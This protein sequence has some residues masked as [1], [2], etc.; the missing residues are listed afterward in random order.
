[1]PKSNNIRI[2]PCSCAH[3]RVWLYI[4]NRSAYLL[5]RKHNT[6]P[7]PPLFPVGTPH[8]PSTDVTNTP[9]PAPP[10][11]TIH[12]A[13]PNPPCTSPLTLVQTAPNTK[14]AINNPNTTLAMIFGSHPSL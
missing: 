6:T 10:T 7:T 3:T 4:L 5:H 13:T 11:P 9:S 8:N 14:L 12:A 2:D 1:M